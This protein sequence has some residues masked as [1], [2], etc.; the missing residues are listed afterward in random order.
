MATKTISPLKPR[1]TPRQARSEATVDAICEAT[2]QVLLAE[3]AARLTTTRVSER[4]GVSVGTMYQYFPNKQALLFAVLKRHMEEVA[5]KVERVCLANAGTDAADML[6]NLLVTYFEAKTSDPEASAA[7]Y[8]VVAE[9]D[10]PELIAKFTNRIIK[11]IETM[12]SSAADLEFTDVRLVT[13]M[14]HVAMIGVIRMIFEHRAGP[15]QIRKLHAELLLMCLSYVQA[16]GI[17]RA[18]AA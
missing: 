12:L 11:A 1:K 13:K 9:L 16:A 10:V 15:A 6:Q 7:I 8:G 2:I 14:V 18:Q 3:G 5:G 4:A 17:A